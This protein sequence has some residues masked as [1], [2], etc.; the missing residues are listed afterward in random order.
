MMKRKERT[1]KYIDEELTKLVKQETMLSYEK[2]SANTA[3]V[4]IK[5]NV[6]SDAD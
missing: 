5:T 3:K 1:F 2:R 6:A 4:E